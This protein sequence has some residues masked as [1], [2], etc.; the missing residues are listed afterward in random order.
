MRQSASQR[1]YTLIELAIVVGILGIILG[2]GLEFYNR[3]LESR[4]VEVTHTRMAVIE[5]ALEEYYTLEKALPCPADG[6][7]PRGNPEYGVASSYNTG[8][9]TCEVTSGTVPIVDLHLPDEYMLDGWNRRF[10]YRIAQGMGLQ[11]DFESPFN[12]GDITVRDLDGNDLTSISPAVYVLISHGQNG[13]FARKI[14]GGTPITGVVAGGEQDNDGNDKTYTYGPLSYNY[15]DILSY[16]GKRHFFR[17]TLERAPIDMPGF[18]C[19]SAE[20]INASADTGA[21]N[22]LVPQ[23][24]TV[25]RIAATGIETICNYNSRPTI[26]APG[27]LVWGLTRNRCSCPTG[28]TYYTDFLNEVFGGCAL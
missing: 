21:Y 5:R 14:N 15:D 7:L 13:V 11:S 2:S 26:C 28:E 27:G 20:R 17:P 9:N 10:S 8:N 23:G 18:V 1:G 3:L 24:G 16:K 25:A 6:S 12:K 22:A 4:K 19:A